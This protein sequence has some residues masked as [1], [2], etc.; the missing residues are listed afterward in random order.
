MASRKGP[1]DP[2]MAELTPSQSPSERIKVTI[3]YLEQTAPPRIS[4]LARPALQMAIM[5]CHEPPATF[6]R[7]IYNAVG[8]PHKWVSRRYLG[9]KELA[10]LITNHTTEIY[11]LYK[12]GWPAGFAEID[13]ADQDK[14]AIRFFGLIPEAQGLGLGRWFFY[15]ILGMIWA[16]GPQSV[17]IDTCTLDSPAALQLYQRAGFNVIDQGT[18]I[19]EWRG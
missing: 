14:P 11:I 9:D 3:T 4:S 10:A 8:G 6:Y 17:R 18:G 2:V 12:E 16:K 1:P 15:E 7:Y 5:K 13:N 19:I